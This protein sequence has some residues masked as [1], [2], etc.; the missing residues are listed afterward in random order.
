MMREDFWDK[1]EFE[2]ALSFQISDELYTQIVSCYMTL[3]SMF[4]DKES[5]LSYYWINGQD[6]ILNLYQVVLQLH[7]LINQNDVLTAENNTLK[8]QVHHQKEL[9]S[10]EVL[11]K[12]STILE[13][14]HSLANDYLETCKKMDDSDTSQYDINDLNNLYLR[15]KGVLIFLSNIK[16]I[17]REHYFNEN[18]KLLLAFCNTSYYKAYELKKC[19]TTF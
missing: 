10:K 14:Y 3:E 7:H 9:D 2:A 8:E 4:P 15:L 16:A 18:E 17:S 6:G 11:Y 1:H 19:T 13:N 12:K 5:M